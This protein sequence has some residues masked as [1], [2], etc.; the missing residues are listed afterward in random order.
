MTFYPHNMCVM[1]MIFVFKYILS[2]QGGN[3]PPMP[4]FGQTEKNKIHFYAFPYL[5]V[6]GV[7]VSYDT[8][9]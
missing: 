1:M 4:P 5:L 8:F 2:A 9:L 7:T 3:P 6:A